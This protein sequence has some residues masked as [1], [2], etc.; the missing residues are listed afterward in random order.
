MKIRG[1]E[2]C[3]RESEEDGREEK[4]WCDGRALERNSAES[5]SDEI[6]MSI[7]VVVTMNAFIEGLGR[8]CRYGGGWKERSSNS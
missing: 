1:R 2:E 3:I 4:R 6:N 5:G 7:C 8:V